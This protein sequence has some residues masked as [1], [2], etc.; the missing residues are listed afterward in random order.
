ML[1]SN[2]SIMEQAYKDLQLNLNDSIVV[3]DKLGIFLSPRAAWTFHYLVILKY[4]Y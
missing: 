1:P 3:Y 2:I 4:I